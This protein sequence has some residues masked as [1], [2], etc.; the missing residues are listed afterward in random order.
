MGVFGFLAAGVTEQVFYGESDW[1]RVG[2]FGTLA[3][4]FVI[5]PFGGIFFGF[6]GDKIG[7]QRCWPSRCC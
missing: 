7:R 2:V 5:R 3:L 1:A 6:L 4:G